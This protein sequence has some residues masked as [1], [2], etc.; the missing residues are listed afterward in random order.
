MAQPGPGRAD[1]RN[2]H[3]R[4]PV[5]ARELP[6]NGTVH[7]RRDRRRSDRNRTRDHRERPHAAGSGP[8]RAPA[9]AGGSGPDAGAR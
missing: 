7:P 2:Q 1:T 6:G 8:V 4:D 5:P 9:E 3:L